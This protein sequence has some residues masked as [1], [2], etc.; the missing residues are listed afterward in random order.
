MASLPGVHSNV[1]A[2]AL[3]GCL[4]TAVPLRR[5]VTLPLG[6]GSGLSQVPGKLYPS[7]TPGM[8]GARTPLGYRTVAPRV[9]AQIDRVLRGCLGTEVPMH[10][11]ATPP[12]GMVS[13][14]PRMP[15]KPYPAR[16]PS[17]TGALT[18]LGCKIVAP[19][20]G[21]QVARLEARTPTG[22]YI[23]ARMLLWWGRNNVR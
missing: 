14:L 20:V 9:V 5:D 18:P 10:R 23:V 15:G 6:V 13:G 1:A 3:R 12:V 8:I 16:M 17:M 2:R 21:A 4:G 19:R 22:D 7:R 11:D